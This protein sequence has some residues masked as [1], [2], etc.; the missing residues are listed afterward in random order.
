VDSPRPGD[1]RLLRIVDWRRRTRVTRI[2]LNQD[3]TASLFVTAAGDCLRGFGVAGSTMYL[4]RPGVDGEEE[5]PVNVATVRD[6][7]VRIWIREDED[8]DKVQQFYRADVTW[9]GEL[10]AKLVMPGMSLG[11]TAFVSNKGEKDDLLAVFGH[12]LGH[13]LFDWSDVAHTS[14]MMYGRMQT[15]TEDKEL[16]C[17]ELPLFYIPEQKER[18]WDQAHPAQ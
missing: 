5:W 13:C 2:S 9:L 18:Q 6:G 4:R 10:S 14:N 1:V 16:R 7:E 17:R 8:W 15:G 11:A 12:E 3:G